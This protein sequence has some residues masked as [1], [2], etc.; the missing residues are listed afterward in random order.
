MKTTMVGQKSFFFAF[1]FSNVGTNTYSYTH[2]WS[3]TGL[4]GAFLSQNT[5]AEFAMMA[6]S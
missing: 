6:T 3:F 1:S 2:A 5:Q 4:D